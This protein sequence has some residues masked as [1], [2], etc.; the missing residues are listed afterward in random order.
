MFTRKMLFTK[1]STLLLTIFIAE[2]CSSKDSDDK[3]DQ[4]ALTSLSDEFNESS[5]WSKWTKA[6]DVKTDDAYIGKFDINQT[7]EGHLYIE[8]VKG[9]WYGENTGHLSFKQ[10]TGDFVAS[11]RVKVA[12]K[13]TPIPQG[14]YDLTGLMARVP[15]QKTGE[16]YSDS[17]ENWEYL[18]TGGHADSR[19][20]DYKKNIRSSFTF[21]TADVNTD[22]I[23]LRLARIGNDIVKLYKEDGG[24]W[25]FAEANRRDDFPDTLQVGFCLL[26]DLNGSP[27]NYTT[28]DYIRFQEP[29][30]TDDMAKKIEDETAEDKDWIALLGK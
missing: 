28:I 27:D 25:Q 6:I 7:S 9:T 5:S 4:V 19:I 15:N 17:N 14:S 10:V 21:Q 11:M 2:G 22:W 20:I 1:V 8:A 16:A 12:G 18:S 3:A 26:T 24:A 13:N 30:L 29:V 23:E